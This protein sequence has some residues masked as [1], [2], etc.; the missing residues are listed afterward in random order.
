MDEYY[1]DMK[2]YE[3]QREQHDKQR[4]ETLSIGKI[5]E[6]SCTD[7]YNR[8]P[9]KVLLT[10]TLP[11]GVICTGYGSGSFDL[12]TSKEIFN[13]HKKNHGHGEINILDD[14]KFKSMSSWWY[15]SWRFFC[16][17]FTGLSMTL[18]FF[19]LMT[20]GIYQPDIAGTTYVFMFLCLLGAAADAPRK[21]Y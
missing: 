17:H 12:Y 15:L 5:I 2:R 9:K 10:K 4:S 13:S 1:N 18:I 3:K 11:N 19:S 8:W 6:T 14:A 20:L 21:H 7:T 16:E